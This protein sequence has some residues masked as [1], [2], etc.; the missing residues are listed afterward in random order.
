MAKWP[1]KYYVGY[2]ESKE[3]INLGMIKKAYEG[4]ETSNVLK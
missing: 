1:K 4:C 3:M 2:Y